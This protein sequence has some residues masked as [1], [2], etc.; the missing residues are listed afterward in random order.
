MRLHSLLASDP[1]ALE[2]ITEESTANGTHRR[3]GGPRA[4]DL[5][6]I[7]PYRDD[8]RTADRPATQSSY[9]SN[10]ERE[11]GRQAS[12]ASFCSIVVSAAMPAGLLD[13]AGG[14]EQTGVRSSS[15]PA[16]CRLIR[17]KAS[18]TAE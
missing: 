9:A 14:L 11:N 2:T 5:L 6:A 3:R 16:T 17:E 12:A 13:L 10:F 4:P 1:V 7:P 15:R 18:F 8:L